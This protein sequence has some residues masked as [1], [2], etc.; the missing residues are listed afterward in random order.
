MDFISRILVM[1][2]SLYLSICIFPALTRWWRQGGKR[3]WHS[4]ESAEGREWLAAG[5][6]AAGRPQGRCRG[7][8]DP[9]FILKKIT[10]IYI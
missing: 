7:S 5:R 1:G 9:L 8:I 10:Y 6:A 3:T 4:A 2:P